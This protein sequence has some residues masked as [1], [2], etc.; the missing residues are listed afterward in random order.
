MILAMKRQYLILYISK[1]VL[2]CTLTV[3]KR[4]AHRGIS[5]EEV[6]RNEPEC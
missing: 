3:E 5:R 6:A 1:K 2:K 4:V